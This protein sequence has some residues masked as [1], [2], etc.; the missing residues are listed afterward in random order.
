MSNNPSLYLVSTME[1]CF[2]VFI[3]RTCAGWDQNSESRDS[4]NVSDLT[5]QHSPNESANDD[6]VDESMESAAATEDLNGEIIGALK[7]ATF[8]IAF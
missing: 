5:T 3:H 7:V 2:I 1:A 6:K 8:N 4:A